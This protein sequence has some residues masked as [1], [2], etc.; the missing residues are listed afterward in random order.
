M[1]LRGHSN[2]HVIE[3]RVVISTFGDIETKRRL[4]VI[5]SEQVIGVV[6]ESGGVGV[7]LGELRGPHSVVGVLGLM[8]GEVGRP[9]SVVDYS[10]SV[11]PLLEEVRPV[12]L[13]GRVDFGG[14]FHESHELSL[15]ET[16]FHEEIVLLMHG[17]V[18]ALAGSLKDLEPSS[19]SIHTQKC[20]IKSHSYGGYYNIYE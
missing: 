5:A 6:D 10:L 20:L 18:T 2:N 7:G 3:V 11:V 15:L 14:V 13:M 4:V 16:L 1:Q 19:Q 9:H 17:S 12:F 8:H